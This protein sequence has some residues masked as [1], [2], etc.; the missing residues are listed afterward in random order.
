MKWDVLREGIAYSIKAMR[1]VLDSELVCLGDDGRTLFHRLLY[2]RDWPFF[3]A[4]DVLEVEAAHDQGWGVFARDR[5][6]VGV[7]AGYHANILREPRV[8]L[9][10]AALTNA[11]TTS[12]RRLVV[13]RHE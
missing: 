8:R 10:A 11:M 6:V 7:I 12:H 4:F 2:R 9:L 1:A 5:F 3:F 13:K